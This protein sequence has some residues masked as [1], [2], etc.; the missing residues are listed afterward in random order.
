MSVSL[1]VVHGHKQG[2]DE[3]EEGC[4]EGVVGLVAYMVFFFVMPAGKVS[5][6][7]MFDI[8]PKP[9]E[10]RLLYVPIIVASFASIKNFGSSSVSAMPMPYVSSG[11]PMSTLIVKVSEHLSN[12]SMLV[13]V[14]RVSLLLRD[15]IGAMN[16]NLSRSLVSSVS[17]IA[18]RPAMRKSINIFK[19][20]SSAQWR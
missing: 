13:M 14:L 9:C 20:S 5:C 12:S 17:S 3:S 6:D 1:Y 4:Q 8:S 18:T 10:P 15:T 11:E 16:V 7:M 2:E 19:Q